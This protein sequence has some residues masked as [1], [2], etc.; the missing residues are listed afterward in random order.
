MPKKPDKFGT[1]FWLLVDAKSKYPCNGKPYLGK[2]PTRIRENDL[3]ADVCLWLMQPFVKKGYNKTKD[4]FFTS[5]NLADKLEA[6]K[7]TLLGAVRKQRKETPKVETMMKSKPLYSTVVYQSPSNVTLTICKAKKAKL[8]YLLSS[9]HKTVCIDETHKKKL[10]ETSKY[11]NLS[12]VG[13]DVL[14]QMARYHTCKS[15]TRRWPVAVFF[16][17]TDCACINAFIIYRKVT[18][19]RL[20]RRKFLL[21]LIK[22]MC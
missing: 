18:R 13:V 15:A 20:S 12:K 19:H 17:I 8:V 5:I 2:D 7:N 1:K 4:N 22:E 6:Q 10:P 14:D 21:Q 9:T 11:Y 16:N 3:P